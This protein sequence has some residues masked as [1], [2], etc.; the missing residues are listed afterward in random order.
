MAEQVAAVETKKCGTCE[1]DIEVSKFR[2]HEVGCARSNYKCPQCGDIVAKA[3]R[4]E[5]E[6][7][8]HVQISCKH[9]NTQ[10]Q[11]RMIEKHE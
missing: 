2:M 9:C 11:K 3:E 4:E 5:H 6:N 1:R 7:E 10:F 8:A